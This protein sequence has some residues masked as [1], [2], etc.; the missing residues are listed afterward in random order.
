MSPVLTGGSI[1]GLVSQAAGQRAHGANI[2]GAFD[3]SFASN[4]P[5]LSCLQGLIDW[6]A[7]GRV[8]LRGLS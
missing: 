5:F 4:G 6:L 8:G 2:S 1:R 7:L 3:V